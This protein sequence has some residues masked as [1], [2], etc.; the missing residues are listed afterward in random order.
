VREVVLGPD[1]IIAEARGVNE[2]VDRV[3]VLTRIEVEY[4]LRIPAGTRERVDRALS[5]HVS[6]CPTAR[7]LEGAVEV[8]WTAEI[9][10][11]DPA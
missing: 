4:R 9:A 3:P 5:R 7:S 10:E 1:D 11:A 8:V 2:L 6:K